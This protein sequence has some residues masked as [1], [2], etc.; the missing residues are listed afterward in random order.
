MK[1]LRTLGTLLIVAG[2]LMLVW[3]GVVWRW[4]DPF[5]A[6][7]TKYEQRQLS[8]QYAALAK[9]FHAAPT[10]PQSIGAEQEALAALAARYRKQTHAGQAI[11][12]IVV[13]R[14]GLD[15]VL[16]DGTDEASLKRG[17]GRDLRTFMPGQGQLIYIAGHRTTY[18]APFAHIDKLRAGDEVRLEVPYGTFVYRV[19]N[20]RVVPASD[21][22]VLRSHGKEVVILQACH[23]RFFASHRYLAYAMPV[24][25]E[26]NGMRPYPVAT[27][28]G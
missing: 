27:A 26:P 16:V 2:L 24:R 10:A 7:Y 13:P 11:G 9:G 4:Q 25:V 17:P 8:K 20:H 22:S 21:L 6:L 15:M 14:L 1:I 23:P 12:H 18:L 5:S 3:A 19:R 28:A